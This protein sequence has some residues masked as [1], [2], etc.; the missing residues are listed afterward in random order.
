MKIVI[1]AWD[2]SL[3]QNKGNTWEDIQKSA[4]TCREYQLFLTRDLGHFGY[5]L[6]ILTWG[7]VTGTE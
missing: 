6:C 2:L 5:S 3:T 1:F 7:F 4:T